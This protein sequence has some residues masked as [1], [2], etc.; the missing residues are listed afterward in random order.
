MSGESS[1]RGASGPGSLWLGSQPLMPPCT[2]HRVRLGLP[3]APAE[4]LIADFHEHG[5]FL[6]W[7]QELSVPTP[8]AR[9]GNDIL[10]AHLTSPRASG[11][12]IKCP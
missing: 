6:G 3:Q 12:R 1:P 5:L 2:G 7:E 10:E 9:V 11:K 4:A 8:Q